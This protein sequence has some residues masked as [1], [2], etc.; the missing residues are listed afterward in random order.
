MILSL[1]K[2]EQ[3]KKCHRR[4]KTLEASLD[5]ITEKTKD[6]EQADEDES[7]RKQ[8]TEEKLQFLEEQLKMT[9]VRIDDAQ[10]QQVKCERLSDSI[11]DEIN[12][13][14]ARQD[15]RSGSRNGR[16]YYCCGRHLKNRIAYN[17]H[18]QEHS[19]L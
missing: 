18:T 6:F 1:R 4:I 8:D 12:Q 5:R 14:I 9:K 2:I 19:L 11:T 16:N 15:T 13:W 7:E 10:R 3:E 17:L